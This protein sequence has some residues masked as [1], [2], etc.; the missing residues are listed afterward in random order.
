M[1]TIQPGATGKAALSVREAAAAASIGRDKLYEMIRN[2]QL[3]ARKAGR[4]TL[5]LPPD[6]QR[7]LE[8]LPKIEPTT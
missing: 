1:K 8:S 4:R 7:S 3:I 6:L 2:G 5:I